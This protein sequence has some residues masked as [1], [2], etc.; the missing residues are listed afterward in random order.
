[1]ATTN[2]CF[3]SNDRILLRNRDLV[4]DIMGRMTFTEA[5]FLLLTGRAPT[6]SEARIVD[7]VLITLM[8]HGLTPQAIATRLIYLSAPE[9]P[10]R[11][12]GSWSPR[13]RRPVR[14]NYG[15]RSYVA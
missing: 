4:K 9:S 13:H 15:G 8:E 3:V 2:L 1:M 14:W 7:T 12:Y 6:P 10:A 5:F 11:R